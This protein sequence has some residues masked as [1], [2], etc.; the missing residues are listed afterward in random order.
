MINSNR[1]TRFCFLPKT[2]FLFK[3]IFK[4]Y[5]YE[6]VFKQSKNADEAVKIIKSGDKVF[7]HSAAAAPARLIQAMTN[8][9]ERLRNVEIYT[10]HTEGPVPYADEKYADSFIIQAFL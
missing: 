2:H 7:I 1:Q 4:T 5:L 8:R 6:S 3:P 10:I 9:A